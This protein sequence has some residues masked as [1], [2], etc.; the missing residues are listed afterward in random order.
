MEKY[1]I[2]LPGELLVKVIYEVKKKKKTKQQAAD[3]KSP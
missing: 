1:I 2:F 3:N